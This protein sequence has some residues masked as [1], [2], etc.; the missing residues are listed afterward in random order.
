MIVSTNCRKNQSIVKLNLI[1]PIK[2]LIIFTVVDANLV[3]RLRQN[4]IALVIIHSAIPENG[5]VEIYPQLRRA[6]TSMVHRTT[7][8]SLLSPTKYQRVRHY[9]RD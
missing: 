1:K 4:T 5:V 8:R 6:R 3:T 7:P 9:V 2:Q